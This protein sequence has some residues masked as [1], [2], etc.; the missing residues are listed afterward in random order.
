VALSADGSVALVGAP[1][2]DGGS[3]AAWLFVRHGDRWLPLPRKLKGGDADGRAGFGRSVALSASG[4]TALVG[5]PIDG[6]GVGAAW[7]F[8]VASASWSQTEKL[9]ATDETGPGQFGDSVA[10]SADGTRGLVGGALD[11]F[12]RGAAWSFGSGSLQTL[13]PPNLRPSSEFGDSVALSGAGTV[14]LVGSVGDADFVGAAWV[15]G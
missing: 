12:G 2:D 4:A 6:N 8:H 10:L 1:G 15:F 9:K 11:D 3:G 13:R 14:A 5:G 7:L